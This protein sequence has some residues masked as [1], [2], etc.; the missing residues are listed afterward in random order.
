MLSADGVPVLM[1]DETVDRTTNGCGRVAD[2]TLAQLRALD[3]GGEPVPTLDD[4]LACC[5]ALALWANIEIKPS[6][7]QEIITGAT[8][9][10]M[11][12]ARWSGSG[13]VSS[14]SSVALAAAR[15]IAP[16]FRYAMLA[17]RLPADWRQVTQQLGL[18]GW[19]LSSAAEATS[20]AAVCNAGL[21]V[22]C[23][24]VNEIDEAQRLFAAG[25]A[26]IFSDRPE[27]WRPAEM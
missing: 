25:V 12:A 16:K 10:R 26:A 8:V 1:H 22:A 13:V 19:H 5:Q 6:A 18:I 11:L 21:C 24:T 3:A 20:L 14:F 7:G 4:A 15:D 9:G 17:D 27:R 2:M 23:Y